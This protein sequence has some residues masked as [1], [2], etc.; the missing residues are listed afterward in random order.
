M[1]GRNTWTKLAQQVLPAGTHPLGSRDMIAENTIEHDTSPL[2]QHHKLR[3]HTCRTWLTGL[4]T[5]I[6]ETPHDTSILIATFI[7]HRAAGPSP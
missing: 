1:R 4:R 2:C 5:D 3:F 6:A 7:S